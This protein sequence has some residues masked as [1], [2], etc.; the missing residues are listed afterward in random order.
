M[1]G[2]LYGNGV[3]TITKSYA[4][5]DVRGTNSYIGGFIG[6]VYVYAN[7]ITISNSFA[8][9]SV[10]GGT[11]A[12]GF[13]GY[14]DYYAVN[15]AAYKFNLQNTYASGSVTGS[16]TGGL[17]A[18][19][20]ASTTLTATNN[21]WVGNTTRVYVSA[22]GTLLSIDE[23]ISKAKYNTWDY[24]NTW[25]L[26]TVIE[27]E[28]LPYLKEL[29]A[30]DNIYV[31]NLVYGTGTGTAGDPFLIYNEDDLIRI[32]DQKAGTYKIMNDIYIENTTNW[33]AIT[34][35]KGTLNGN[36]KA[37]FGLK[38]DKLGTANQGL[39]ANML[40]GARVFDLMLENVNIKGGQFT[41]ALCRRYKNFKC[42]HYKCYSKWYCRK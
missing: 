21:Y 42:R 36:N 5:G 12:G 30:P 18:T 33:T 32:K 22:T 23:A 25:D 7:P 37:I 11:Y 38:I 6:R 4:S 41:G 14:Q 29:P 39:F 20:A 40:A 2:Y 17:V 28:S 35:F 1:I 34:D 26:S 3:S 27:N 24:A 8:S 31:K 10:S 15:N 9:G 19:M 13:I 16:T